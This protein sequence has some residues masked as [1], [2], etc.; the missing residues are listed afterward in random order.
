[1]KDNNRLLTAKVAKLESARAT[2]IH[3]L[4]ANTADDGRFGRAFEVSCARPLSH[5]TEVS[6]QNRADVS[7]KML[8]DGKIQYVHAECK[9]N[10]GRVNDLLDGSNKSK[11]VIYRLDTVQKHKATKKSPEWIETRTVEPVIVP[12]DLF[13]QMLKECNALKTIA[14]GGVVDGIGIQ[15]SSKKM[16]ERLTAYVNN[17]GEAVIFD[18]EH[19][20]E[21]WDFDGLEL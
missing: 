1:M 4:L 9:T 15:V 13:L 5:K 11:F 12:T 7:I 18:R 14:H 21:D 17:Y 6:A 20:Y 8:V 16:Y 3:N 19:V 2:T 10:G